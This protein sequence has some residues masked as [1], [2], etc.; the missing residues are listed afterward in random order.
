MK[1]IFKLTV[2]SA[3][4]ALCSISLAVKPRIVLVHGAFADASCWNLVVEILQS[5]G[6]EVEAV[7]NDMHSLLSDIEHTKDR[8]RQSSSPTIVVGHSYGGAVISGA[9]AGEKNVKALVFIAAFTPD[10]GESLQAITSQGIPAEVTK[11]IRPDAKGNLYLT[12]EGFINYFANH[13]PASMAKAMAVSQR[14]VNG[15]AFG[16]FLSYEPAWRAIPSFYAVSKDDKVIPAVSLT[17]SLAPIRF[18]KYSS[19]AAGITL[20]S[21]ETA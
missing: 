13:I 8:I 21:F 12:T 19:A 15:A 2:A 11:F 7:Q 9:A 10:K 17:V 4:F 6:Y 14:P 18:A 1:T 3:L 16:E 20:S 5:H